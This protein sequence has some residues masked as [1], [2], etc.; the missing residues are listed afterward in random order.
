M[1]QLFQSKREIQK[2]ILDKEQ[3]EKLQKEETFREESELIRKDIKTFKT[4][5]KERRE[6]KKSLQKMVRE[7]YQD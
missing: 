4:L 7:F 3:Q 5:E 6:K 1:H 2:Q